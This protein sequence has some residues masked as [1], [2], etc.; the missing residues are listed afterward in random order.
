MTSCNLLDRSEWFR[1]KTAGTTFRAEDSYTL[2]METAQYFQTFVHTKPHGVTS[3]KTA[4]FIFTVMRT[5]YFSQEKSSALD[6]TFIFNGLY[7][8]YP[9]QDNTFTS[10]GLYQRWLNSLSWSTSRSWSLFDV[11][12]NLYVASVLT[13]TIRIIAFRYKPA[14]AMKAF[15]QMK[16]T[17]QS[18]EAVWQ[19]NF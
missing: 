7:V 19:I 4:T 16:I 13:V 6:N 2:K 18:S 10:H 9:V 17:N 15:S 14:S 8:D 12:S 3:K 5:L 11:Y 1:G